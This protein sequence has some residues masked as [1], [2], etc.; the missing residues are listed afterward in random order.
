MRYALFATVLA[1]SA[2]ILSSCE[3]EAPGVIFTEPEKPLLD[4]SYMTSSI[5]AVEPKRIMLFDITG[6]RCNNCPKAAKAAENIV[7]ANPGRVQVIALYPNTTGGPLITPWAGTDTMASADAEALVTANGSIS[8]LPT[9]MVDQAVFGSSRFMPFT[10][11]A[12]AVTGRLSLTTPVQIDLKSNWLS[13][14]N[15]GRLEVKAT[16]ATAQTNKHLIFIGITESDRIGIQ[17]DQDTAGGIRYGYPHSHIL[18]KL[19]TSTTGDTLS[20]T[21]VAGRVF[22]KHYY[23]TP[24]YNWWPDNL[25]AQVWIVD[26]VTKEVLHAEEVKLKP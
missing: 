24:R 1:A 13:A 18:R 19:L 3:E 6:V 7:A 12:G 25:H 15:R 23:V 14:Q 20:N 21:L 26:A 8:S 2:L 4:T 17:S 10:N 5:P 16:Y 22:E 11:W 9:G